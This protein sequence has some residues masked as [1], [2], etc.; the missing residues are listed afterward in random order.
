MTPLSPTGRFS[1]DVEDLLKIVSCA[2][3]REVHEVLASPRGC[4]L[5]NVA[6]SPPTRGPL[7]A[8]WASDLPLYPQAYSYQGGHR[9]ADGEVAEG[10]ADGSDGEG[11][12]ALGETRL[13][14]R[15]A[16]RAEG[17][18]C[19]AT[20]WRVES[21]GTGA[22]DGWGGS[23][24]VPSISAGVSTASSFSPPSRSRPQTPPPNLAALEDSCD[25][26][27]CAHA[28]LAQQRYRAVHLRLG[29]VRAPIAGPSA[30][31]SKAKGT[32]KASPKR[33][34]EAVKAEAPSSG[35]GSGA[36]RSRSGGGGSS[37]G[38]SW[39]PPAAEGLRLSASAMDATG[40]LARSL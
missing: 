36:S 26:A 7:E 31:K 40:G 16:E 21:D 24:L 20:E 15:A 13:P 33:K 22:A 28:L 10:P 19:E 9:P 12:A 5:I 30:A 2:R 17:S 38:S 23:S 14:R 29:G 18:S 39:R 3:A 37:S 8:L 27:P 34:A 11:Y 32:T 6:A 25:V 1:F 35:A 4:P